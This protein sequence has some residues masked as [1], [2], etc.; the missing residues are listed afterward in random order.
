MKHPDFFRAALLAVAIAGLA[1]CAKQDAT[2]GPVAAASAT[3]FPLPVLGAAPE[4]KLKDVNGAVVSSEQFKGKVLGVDF[5]ATWCG[6]CRME[7][8]G[9]VELQNKYG[10][11]GFVMVG[12]SMDQEGPAV[13]KSFVEKYAVPYQM[14]MNDDA[15]TAAFGPID[16]IPTTFLIDREGKVRDR[17]VGAEATAD[18][19]KKI[20]S[21][22]N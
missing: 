7:I 9:Y 13:V 6:P 11:D 22:L 10:K 21:L 2:G 8:P 1:A 20:A 18:Y 16:A 4:W 19:E 14:V 3:A 17:K 12:V 15:V 5:W